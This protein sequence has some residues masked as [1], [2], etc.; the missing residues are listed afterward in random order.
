MKMTE[1]AYMDDCYAKELDATV[2]AAEGNNLELDRTIFC[3]QAGGV[4]CDKGT[5]GCG[6]TAYNVV[7]VKKDKGRVLHQLEMPG[8]K[9]G[10]RVHLSLDWDRRYLLMRYHTSAH[11]ISGIFAKDLGAKITGNSLTTEKGRID[12][13]LES[14]DRALIEQCFDKARELIKKDLPIDIYS[15]PRS[16][17]E[18]KPEMVKLAMGLPP[19]IKVLRIVDIKGFDAQPDG[20]CHVKSLGEVGEIKF[21]S[22]DNKGKSNR[23]V[24][25]RLR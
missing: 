24:Y 18:S 11:L 23:R 8:L 3:P 6:E 12:F 2:T 13:D 16:D 15:L 21:L 20:G 1:L 25:Y 9:L 4:E 14:F 22:A 7:F 17:V 5:M 19:N 10:D